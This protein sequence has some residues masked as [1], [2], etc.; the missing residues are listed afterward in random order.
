MIGHHAQ[1]D[2]HATLYICGPAAVRGADA[3]ERR[4][5]EQRL[6][7]VLGLGALAEVAVGKG[8]DAAGL[9]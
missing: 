7:V 4:A 5:G 3:L 2:S 8:A 9:A 1:H 6:R